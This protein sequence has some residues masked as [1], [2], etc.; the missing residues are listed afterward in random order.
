MSSFSGKIILTFYKKYEEILLYLIVGVLTT[1]VS[2][3]T[4]Y[5]CV[6]TFLDPIDPFQLQLANI[7]AWVVAVTFAYVTNRIFVFKSKIP[8]WRKEALSFYSSRIVTLFLDMLIMFI[9]VTL[10]HLNDKVAKLVVQVV[11][12]I[13]NYVLSKWFVFKKV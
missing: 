3:G 7:I 10:L 2:L 8:D 6:L 9:M 5:G 1:I 4:Y 12:T 13:G 11:V